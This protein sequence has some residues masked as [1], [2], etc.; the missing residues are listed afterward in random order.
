MLVAGLWLVVPLLLA[1]LTAAGGTPGRRICGLAVV[2]V[3]DGGRAGL[4]TAL[5]RELLG[6]ALVVTPLVAAG[7]AGL[8]GYVWGTR[9]RLGQTWQDRIGRTTVL[10][11]RR[12]PVLAQGPYGPVHVPRIAPAPGGPRLR[13]VGGSASAPG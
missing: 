12:R 7:G 1:L 2:R 8:L 13:R 3:A 6:R 5:R 4:G 9:D 10:D 11:V